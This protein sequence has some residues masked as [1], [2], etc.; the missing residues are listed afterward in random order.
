MIEYTDVQEKTIQKHYEKT[1]YVKS[2]V[3][4]R[5]EHTHY[6]QDQRVREL[7]G[8]RKCFKIEHKIEKVKQKRWVKKTR[9]VKKPHIC[10]HEKLVERSI[11]VD[12][13]EIEADT[14][15][16]T[17]NG[18][19][20]TPIQQQEV[21]YERP[22]Y[23]IDNYNVRPRQEILTYPD[24]ETMDHTVREIIEY[25]T[26]VR[27]RFVSGDSVDDVLNHYR[28]DSNAIRKTISVI[29]SKPETK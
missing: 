15:N 5:V 22:K 9:M 26:G 12:T 28:F 23:R 1:E 13:V 21:M 25:E 27:A 7:A 2:E 14:Q 3:T 18:Y 24:L 11:N 8:L 17:R 19:E 6:R 4:E 20:W 16:R 10:I 29:F